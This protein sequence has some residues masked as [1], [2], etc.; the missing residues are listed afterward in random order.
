MINELR[1][2]KKL[3]LEK[4]SLLDDSTCETQHEA[5][6]TSD[7]WLDY[8]ERKTQ[9][10]R[11]GFKIIMDLALQI[12]QLKIDLENEIRLVDELKVRESLHGRYETF[13]SS[14]RL[15]T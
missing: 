7:V 9:R 12:D 5:D 6:L 10:N 1:E 3:H 8:Q 4:S 14:K 15:F 13:T 11:E 2:T